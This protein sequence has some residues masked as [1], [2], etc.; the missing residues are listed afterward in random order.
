MQRVVALGGGIAGIVTATHL[1]RKVGRTNA[2]KR[3]L[4]EHLLQ[5]IERA[6]AIDLACFHDKV[7]LSRR[8]YVGERVSR[9]GDDVCLLAGREHSQIVSL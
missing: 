5:N 2:A 8:R 3:R 1:A 7:D 9:H 6:V 4:V